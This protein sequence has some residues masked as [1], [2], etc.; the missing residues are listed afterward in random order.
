MAFAF[1]EGIIDPDYA[2]DAEGGPEFGNRV[3]Q[4][5]D[6]GLEAITIG[7]AKARHRYTLEWQM[8]S[9][10]AQKGL[11]DFFYALGGI[12]TGFRLIAPD[13]NFLDFVMLWKVVARD[14]TTVRVC[15]WD[16]DLVFDAETYTAMPLE[17][18]EI[19]TSSGLQPDDAEMTIPLVDPFTSVN[20]LGGKWRGAR[21]TILVVEAYHLDEGPIRKHTSGE[22]DGLEEEITSNTSG[23][24]SLFMPMFGTV[25]VGDTVSAVEGCD[26]SK[27]RCAAIVNADNPSGTNIENMRAEPFLPGRTRVFQYPP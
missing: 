11:R 15:N 3:F 17:P 9:H 4:S 8:M 7:R 12:K 20:I 1:F 14:G 27:E 23:E 13:D 21:V 26:R 6:S 19:Q 5:P 10:A 18:T 25:E 2:P 16:S 24:L 22:N